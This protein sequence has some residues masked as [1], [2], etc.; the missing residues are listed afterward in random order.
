MLSR[1]VHVA[2]QDSALL[3]ARLDRAH[4]LICP[5]ADGL[6]LRGCV[7][8]QARAR[9]PLS[10]WGLYSGG[11]LKL[12]W[13]HD[14]IS[15]RDGRALGEG[16]LAGGQTEASAGLWWGE[17][18]W[19]V[20]LVDFILRYH[21][22]PGRS[23]TF[24]AYKAPGRVTRSQN[25]EALM[26]VGAASSPFLCWARDIFVQ[27]AAGCPPC[28]R[29][30]DTAAQSAADVEASGDSRDPESWPW[31]PSAA[32]GCY[33]LS[34]KLGKWFVSSGTQFPHLQNG[35]DGMCSL[36]VLVGVLRGGSRLLDCP[37]WE[38]HGAGGIP[39]LFVKLFL[40]L[41]CFS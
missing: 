4:L 31:G 39:F 26:G 35:E 23:W 40:F 2:A 21:R 27:E 20:D 22:S 7:S 41:F 3:L 19:E 25:G 14:H 17:G 5:P 38:G 8:Q 10:P 11:C 12:A 37:S 29:P 16:S 15:F 36:R 33:P 13:G 32:V 30:G 28:G 24:A 9:S 18:L 1:R 34:L 6:T